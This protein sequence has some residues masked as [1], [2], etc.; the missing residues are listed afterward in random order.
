MSTSIPNSFV[1]CSGSAE[2]RSTA[3]F[4]LNRT[5]LPANFYRISAFIRHVACSSSA[6]PLKQL[7]SPAASRMLF[8][9][10]GHFTDVWASHRQITAGSR[11]SRTPEAN[12]RGW[13]SDRRNAQPCAAAR[14]AGRHLQV[15]RS[16]SPTPFRPMRFRA[17]QRLLPR[18]VALQLFT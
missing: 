6:I 1:R 13:C 12:I 18:S 2:A 3:P 4:N 14:S 10:P 17:L 5:F 9:S 11:K 8:T 7:L 16:A 15:Q